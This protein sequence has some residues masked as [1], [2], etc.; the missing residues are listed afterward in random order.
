MLK[1]TNSTI[2]EFILQRIDSHV[3]YITKK[4]ENNDS[5]QV[6]IFTCNMISKKIQQ[7]LEE[8]PNE[9][10]I[11]INKLHKLLT[12]TYEDNSK[13]KKY[14]DL[15]FEVTLDIIDKTNCRFVKGHNG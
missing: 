13:N 6:F 5:K 8:T 11:K 12:N 3:E 1:N 14:E 2:N 10:L 9:I 7:D 15:A 4:I